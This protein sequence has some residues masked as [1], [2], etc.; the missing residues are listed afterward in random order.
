MFGNKVKKANMNEEAST[1]ELYGRSR[2]TRWRRARCLG[3][4]RAS[5]L[6]HLI[7]EGV[8]VGRKRVSVSH[9]TF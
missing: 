2:R 5:H 8:N 9:P 1:I 7:L 4:G 6:L 3:R